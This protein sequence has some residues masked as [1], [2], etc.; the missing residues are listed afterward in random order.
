MTSKVYLAISSEILGG[1]WLRRI[2][3][4]AHKKDDFTR[5]RNV[6]LVHAYV[7]GEMGDRKK[8]AREMRS[9]TEV[10]VK[11]WKMGK[12]RRAE[13]QSMRRWKTGRWNTGACMSVLH[14]RKQVPF[15]PLL[16]Q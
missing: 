1:C 7:H 3:G 8:E 16:S 4:G 5:V 12:K 11:K 13:S 2:K 15:I 6:K 14:S 10:E 9:V